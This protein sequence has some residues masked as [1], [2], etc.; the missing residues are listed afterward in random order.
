MPDVM[1]CANE[2]G[3]G[4]EECGAF[5]TDKRETVKI[6]AKRAAR[7]TYILVDMED[8][9]FLEMRDEMDIDPV[10]EIRIMLGIIMSLMGQLGIE[11]DQKQV[12]DKEL[13]FLK[14]WEEAH[15]N[16]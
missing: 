7:L 16:S 4:V 15:G 11:V 3:I 9:P 5:L 13:R 6:I 8:D 10:P 1:M 14:R 2:L 12:G